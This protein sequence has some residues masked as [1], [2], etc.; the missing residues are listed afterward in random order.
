MNKI[1]T[2][3]ETVIQGIN[4]MPSSILSKSDV[5]DLLTNLQKLI[6]VGVDNDYEDLIADINRKFSHELERCND[7][8]DYSSAE[9]EFKN[10]NTIDLTHVEL[11]TSTIE[12]LLSDILQDVFEDFLIQPSD[13][14][15]VD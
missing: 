6:I 9:F 2:E 10:S 13:T 14:N 5:T 11:D 15:G 12:D 7:I 8:I 1:N 4:N 3:F